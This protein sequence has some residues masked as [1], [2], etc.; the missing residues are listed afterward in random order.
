MI[1]GDEPN[2]SQIVIGWI[3]IGIAFGFLLSMRHAVTSACPTDFHF[4]GSYPSDWVE[5]IREG[6]QY[7][8]S[9]REQAVNLDERLERNHVC[10][11]ENKGRMDRAVDIALRT[12]APAGPPAPCFWPI[13]AIACS[14]AAVSF[15]G[16]YHHFRVELPAIQCRE[17][18]AGLGA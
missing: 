6:T 2:S 13:L 12:L 8:P 18:P 15:V 10:L 14:A 3:A 17:A 5:T 4:A 1:L 9:L 11:A 7:E 16:T